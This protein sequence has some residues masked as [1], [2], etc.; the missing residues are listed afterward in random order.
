MGTILFLK[1]RRDRR[2]VCFGML[3]VFIAIFWGFGIFMSTLTKNEQYAVFWRRIA[4][5]GVFGAPVL[6]YHFV[7][8]FLGLKDRIYR[9]MLVFVYILGGVLLILDLFFPQET[10]VGGFRFVFGQFY[11]AD[12]FQYRSFIYLVSHICFY[13]F[14]L[15]AAFL[16]LLTRFK[17]STGIF[18]NQLKYF[19]L[20]SM[21]GWLGPFLMWLIEFRV[22]IYPY[23]QFFVVM[24]PVIITY[25]IVK[26]H[27]LDIRIVITRIGIFSGV[28][29][30]LLGIPVYIGYT[31]Q[32]WG[33]SAFLL[34]V[35]AGI[36]PF[37]YRYLQRKA[38]D[39]VFRRSRQY[40][41][42]LRQSSEDMLKL[43]D[44]DTL[45]STLCAL[46]YTNVSP[47]YVGAYFFAE[48]KYVLKT[49]EPSGIFLPE[50]LE[51]SNP[52]IEKLYNYDGRL[53]DE[54]LDG[55]AVSLSLVIGDQNNPQGLLVVGEK[56][57]KEM[58]SPEDVDTFKTLLNQVSLAI[59]N[60]HHVK[61]MIE[62]QREKERLKKEMEMAKQ[63]QQS[64]LP[65]RIPEV[66]GM[67]LEGVLLPA[68]E[69]AGDYYDF[70][71]LGSGKV[72][73]VVADVSGKGLDS[74][75]VM[76]MTKATLLPLSREQLTPREL[77]VKLNEFLLQQLQ[78]QKFIALIY[79]E[80]TAINNTFTWA[81][82]GQEHVIVY[83]VAQR[84]VEVIKTGGIV[85]GMFDDIRDNIY[86]QSLVLD[87]G[88]RLIL[89]T[90]GVTEAR[91]SN[92]E[93][94]GRSRLVETIREISPFFSAKETL[95][96]VMDKIHKHIGDAPQFDDI[97]IVVL[98][99]T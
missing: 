7:Y 19:I 69:V 92:D 31:S 2:S 59:E 48:N 26:Y 58:Y 49:V 93:M 46:I 86:Q 36:G 16:L 53:L 68:R 97:T 74:G 56:E 6:Y 60:I 71:S 44:I 63:I 39:V 65:Q 42:I 70:I 33:I 54:E 3:C 88:D 22:D 14:L 40:Q 13:W 87:K 73:I 77:I 79:G 52:F 98:R 83:R 57:D 89:Y 27:M 24:Y 64:L 17:S 18:R 94:F 66:E 76:S 30:L 90:D 95:S 51:L 8:L 29:T 62:E 10:F 34:V 28:Y 1:G 45:F 67:E 84:N 11:Y 47:R 37:I 91:D 43:Q 20:G 96:Y 25:G 5:I 80:Y 81:G 99:K 78:Q 82:A 41:K 12:W 38:E 75:M 61:A 72:G 23:S 15:P 9:I 35:F 50:E 21:L 4:N 55:I 85:L 32:Q